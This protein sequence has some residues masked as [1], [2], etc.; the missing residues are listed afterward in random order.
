MKRP[1]WI[2]AEIGGDRSS[3]PYWNRTKRKSMEFPAEYWKLFTN[4]GIKTLSTLLLFRISRKINIVNFPSIKR[5]FPC[6][7]HVTQKPL[8][9]SGNST[10]SRAILVWVKC[11]FS[12]SKCIKRVGRAVNCHREKVNNKPDA[13]SVCLRKHSGLYS[14]LICKHDRKTSLL[15]KES[16]NFSKSGDHER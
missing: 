3:W 10:G 4:K 9:C 5:I 8:V 6:G 12:L 1:H 7:N 2:P 14:S 15:L 11:I 16:K 13:F